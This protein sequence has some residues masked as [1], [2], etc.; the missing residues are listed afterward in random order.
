MNQLND[1]EALVDLALV[2]IFNDM[3]D[4]KN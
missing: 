2:V 1:I 4:E 3:E